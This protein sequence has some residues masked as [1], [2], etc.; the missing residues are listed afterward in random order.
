MPGLSFHI[1]TLGCQMNEQDSLLLHERLVRAGHRPALE[2]E[3]ADVLIVNTCSIRQKAEEKAYS[4]LGRF[5]A[6]KEER[7]GVLVAVGGCLSQQKGKTLLRRMPGVDL[8]FGPGQGSRIADLLEALRAG[9]GPLVALDAGEWT[10]EALESCGA[11]RQGE[12]KAYLKIMEGCDN[13]CSYCIVPYVR[14]SPRSRPARSIV[15]EAKTLVGMGVKEITL[16]G[17]NVSAYRDPD[18]PGFGFAEL[19]ETVCNRVQ[20]VRLRFTTSHPKDTTR[21]LIDSFG[22]L[23]PLCEHMHLPLQS[24]SDR[25][26]AAMGRGYTV[27]AYREIVLAL[28]ERCPGISITSDVI[29]GFPEESQRDFERTLQVVREI[30][31]DGLFSFKFSPR[32]GTRAASLKETVPETQKTERLETL[33]RVQREIGL[34]KN[35]ALEGSVAEILVEGKSRRGGFWTGRTRTNRIVNVPG[36]AGWMGKLV[37]V[38]IERGGPHSLL[39][40]ALEGAEPSGQTPCRPERKVS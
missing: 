24:G 8:V 6:L 32:P 21:D 16:L 14:G 35:K 31:F 11:V 19:L 9:A 13:F 17:Q 23:P 12:V 28:R 26:L 20:P 18:R 34:E 40:R 30:R 10:D 4:I 5:R 2:A 29:V 27:A 38:R 1:E 7:P 15:A 25:V 22:K 37:S 3:D 36:P 39:G 33:Q